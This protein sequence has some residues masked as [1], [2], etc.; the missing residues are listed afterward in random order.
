MVGFFSWKPNYYPDS[1]YSDKWTLHLANENAKIHAV[2]YNRRNGCFLSIVS[3]FICYKLSICMS[4][5][6]DEF[7][8]SALEKCFII[9]YIKW[10]LIF[11]SLRCMIIICINLNFKDLVSFN[12]GSSIP[13]SKQ[14]WEI[15][16][17]SIPRAVL[18]TAMEESW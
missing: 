18:Y 10:L 5:Y 9:K 6:T 13:V 7:Y 17:S 1:P 14:C 3:Y 2:H 4:I 15:L 8:V 11:T 16:K 12:R